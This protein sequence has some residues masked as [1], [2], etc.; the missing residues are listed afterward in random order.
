ME[1]RNHNMTETIEFWS[2]NPYKNPILN[3]VW[4]TFLGFL[5]WNVWKERNKIIFK[6]K[7]LTKAQ[8]WENI[9]INVKESISAVPWFFQDLQLEA[10][11]A[12]IFKK[13]HLESCVK[14][15]YL[16]QKMGKTR[17]CDQWVHPREGFIKLNFDRASKGNPGLAGAGGFFRD[18]KG[19][20]ILAYVSNMG[21]SSNNSTELVG[22]LRGMVIAE[23]HEFLALVVEGESQLVIVALQ[24]IMNG[25]NVD[26][27][28][29]HWRMSYG[30]FELERLV[31]SLA[32]IVLELVHRK[33]NSVVNCMANLGVTMPELH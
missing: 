5:M 4:E 7:V 16:V 21:L 12:V 9:S 1:L 20:V 28:S 18:H 10:H 31:N 8:M 24:K 14:P 15:N 22:L 11:E 19:D 23:T 27:V 26:K 29:Q 13:W 30:I 32:A 2:N 25:V 6:Y 17:I 33:S 3:R